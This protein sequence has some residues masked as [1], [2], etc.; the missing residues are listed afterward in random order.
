[1]PSFL[2]VE[3]IN[4]CNYECPKC[5]QSTGLGRPHA[6]MDVELFKDLVAQLKP[7]RPSVTL[8]HSGEPMLHPKL[9]DFIRISREAG[10]YT[11]VVTNAS[12]LHKDD[13]RITREGPDAITFSVDGASPG[14]YEPAHGGAPW[15][16]IRRN[17]EE[18]FKRL[19]SAGPTKRVQI[20]MVKNSQKPEEIQEFIDFAKLFPFFAV[21]IKPAF[22]WPDG[23]AVTPVPEFPPGQF[24][25]PCG[26]PWLSPAIL[27]DGTVVPCCIDARRLYPVGNI[28]EKPF[29]DIFNSDRFGLLRRHLMNPQGTPAIPL[30]DSCGLKR[31][32]VPMSRRNRMLFRTMPIWKRFFRSLPKPIDV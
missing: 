9:F 6:T 10:L 31:C 21:L 5:P 22:V 1:M 17:I 11:I 24:V 28:R 16:T 25:F 27:A 12:L 4:M 32:A 14:V 20:S 8:H 7:Y 3:P 13:F 18:F 15:E 26:H 23:K 29:M 2:F 19:D 30:C